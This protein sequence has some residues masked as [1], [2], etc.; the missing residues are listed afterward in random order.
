V[1]SNQTQRSGLGQDLQVFDGNPQGF[2]ISTSIGGI[3]QFGLNLTCAQI[4]STVKY[5]VLPDGVEENN[6]LH[7]KAGIFWSENAVWE[8]VQSNL[9][10]GKNK[11]FPLAYLMEAADDIS[12][13]LSDIEDGIEKGYTT[14]RD[15]YEALE[16]E[17]EKAK[18]SVAFY[19]KIKREADE[20]KASVDPIVYLRTQLVRRL[21]ELASEIY[22][23]NHESVLAGALPGLLDGNEDEACVLL[24]AIKNVVKVQLYGMIA[25][26]EI[27]LG[28]QAAI[29]GT[30]CRLEGLLSLE[31]SD[32]QSLIDP[33]QAP[34]N[35]AEESRLLSLLPKKY[36]AAYER[37]AKT[38]E[39]SEEIFHRA[40]LMVDY[41]AGMTDVFAISVYRKLSGI[42]FQ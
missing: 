9:E 7:K 33:D 40:H 16:K 17:F 18:V 11:R 38:A 1:R 23:H 4:A 42:K 30:L 3:D 32:F 22:V 21:V 24:S 41:V 35:L 20:Y 10:L 8:L 2:R 15:F 19:Y 13:C 34:K 31:R 25:S 39:D 37:N 6:S 29:R 14:Y 12:Y 36:V 28:G 26:V 5:P 27:E